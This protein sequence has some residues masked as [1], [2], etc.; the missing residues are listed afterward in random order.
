MKTTKGEI[1]NK[2][3]KKLQENKNVKSI[4]QIGSS[5]WDA[6]SKDIDLIVIIK[7]DIPSYK[8]MKFLTKVKEDFT[9]KFGVSFGKGGLFEKIKTF[10]IDLILI[11]ESY[12]LFYSFN[13]LLIYGMSL[14]QYKILYGYDFFKKIRGVMKPDKE[15][16]FKFGG[17]LSNF[18]FSF[19]LNFSD[20]VPKNS[21]LILSVLKIILY[22]LVFMK[23]RHVKKN[24]L[25]NFL[26]MNYPFFNELYRKYKIKDDILYKENL[27]SK[28]IENLY[29]FLRELIRNIYLQ[30]VE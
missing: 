17:P 21:K 30:F 11:P 15:M 24:E 9:K 29:N 4:M 16:L 26:R 5:L 6:K 7:S 18:Y 12:Q 1:L 13:P 14:N 20:L 28:E 3:V 23:G 25:I 2:F 22:P 8:D 27:T 19:I 10:N